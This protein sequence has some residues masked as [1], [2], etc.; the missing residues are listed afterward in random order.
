MKQQLDSFAEL[1]NL[2]DEL[3]P[4]QESSYENDPRPPAG[5]ELKNRDLDMED[6]AQ[7]IGLKREFATHVLRI[8]Y[9]WLK[10]LAS[11]FITSIVCNICQGRPG[12][13]DSV[14]IA[15][16]SGTSLSV[17][18]GMLSIILRYLFVS[19]KH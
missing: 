16:V 14:L 8:T 7:D 5:D 10:F 6:K 9:G 13:S 4:E 11:L 19:K 18:I 2:F 1:S 17:I 3:L 15:L 12:I